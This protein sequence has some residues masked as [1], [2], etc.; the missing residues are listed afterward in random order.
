MT[1]NLSDEEYKR[2]QKKLKMRRYRKRLKATDEGKDPDFYITDEDYVDGYQGESNQVSPAGD[3]SL[4]GT[5]QDTSVE[6]VAVTTGTWIALSILGAV[7]AGAIAIPLWIAK[8][9]A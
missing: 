8:H 9:A 3:T 7:F 2:L 5:D 1:D 6:P 4:P